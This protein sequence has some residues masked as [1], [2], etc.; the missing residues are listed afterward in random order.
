MWLSEGGK[1]N[2]ELV[3]IKLVDPTLLNGHDRFSN[4]IIAQLYNQVADR[5]SSPVIDRQVKQQFN[6]ALTELAQ[7]LEKSSEFE[8]HTGIDRV[9][10]YR[11]GVQLERYFHQFV[12]LCVKLLGCQAIVLPIDDVD[13]AL[14]R[15]FEVLDDVRRLLSCPYII[16]LV[17]GD[18]LLFDQVT[19]VHFEQQAS[20]KNSSAG[21]RDNG[22][23]IAKN[24]AAAYLTKIFPYHLRLPLKPINELLP[25]LKIVDKG[26][27]RTFDEYW[28]HLSWQFFPLCNSLDGSAT[29]PLP[30]NAREASQ[31]IRMIKP[32]QIK[33]HN[34]QLEIWRNYQTWSELKRSGENYVNARSVSQ[35]HSIASNKSWDIRCLLAF[36]PMEQSQSG[37][38]FAEYPFAATQRKALEAF[39]RKKDKVSNDAILQRALL[40]EFLPSEMTTLSKLPPLEFYNR[41]LRLSKKRLNQMSNDSERLSLNDVSLV[42][43]YTEAHY[44]G[45][46]SDQA[47]LVYFSRAFEVLAFSMLALTD[48]KSTIL[49]G[50]ST[51]QSLFERAPFYSL[52]ALTPLFEFEVEVEGEAEAEAELDLEQ[53]NEDFEQVSEETDQ[54]SQSPSNGNEGT[55]QLH[56]LKAQAIA[57]LYQDI[58]SWCEEHQQKCE[59]VQGKSLI[60]ILNLVFNKVFEQINEF[61]LAFTP[62]K[63]ASEDLRTLARRFEYM[64]IN[65][66]ASFINEGEV[67]RGKLAI[68]T[69]V[70][71]F[72]DHA[73]FIQRDRSLIR[74]LQGLLKPED[75][76]LARE[77]SYA[78]AMFAPVLQALW[79]H[80]IFTLN[81]SR[82]TLNINEEN[83][84]PMAT[85][86]FLGEVSTAFS[87][88]DTDEQVQIDDL[89]TKHEWNL[90]EYLRPKISESGI[91]GIGDVRNFAQKDPTLANNY[92]DLYKL[93]IEKHNKQEN[94]FETLSKRSYVGK[95]Y[96]GLKQGIAN[97]AN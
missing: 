30:N 36:N 91:F 21:V 10:K 64:V 55:D 85:F 39:E 79:E 32:K 92:M 77:S 46:Q 8:D 28:L 68:G 5:L 29:V 61:R 88:I 27:K 45:M 13:M 7:A 96:H 63:Y 1:D 15:A 16:P 50:I 43:L 23:T 48:N 33:H 41:D 52:Q 40:D 4:V 80:P 18:H 19:T 44:Y 71:L 57:K 42:S 35:L 70:S 78:R 62:S 74:N 17:S 90:G 34:A 22:N 69:D 83:R 31:L 84:L 56:L 6:Q 49:G 2:S 12:E 53:N 81:N 20:S 47:Y 59:Q 51:F 26:S 67:V 97:A 24:L 87:N 9:L 86:K 66:F 93:W 54:S 11:S 75:G 25:Q 94:Y 82:G 14:G 38:S 37:L 60:P 65:A 3:F 95:I 89:M 72:Y 58:I 73:K 76:T